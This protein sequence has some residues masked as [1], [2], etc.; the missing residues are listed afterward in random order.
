ML[1]L[2]LT[3]AVMGAQSEFY[4]QEVVVS[5]S[6]L[7]LREHPSVTSGNVVATL[8]RGT[9]LSVLGVHND[10]EVVQVD[11][12]FG[13]WYKVQSAKGQTGY[14]F[15]AFVSST[16]QVLYEDE[17]IPTPQLPPL[18]WYGVYQRD[19][20]SDEVRRID[21]RLVSQYD[22]LSD[23][24][25]KVLKTNQKEHSKFVIGSLNA[26]PLGYVGPLGATDSPGWFFEGGLEPGAM[27]PISVGQAPGDSTVGETYFLAATG[28]AALKNNFVQ[29]SGYQLQV[30]ELRADDE[31]LIQNL[32]P[33]VNPEMG[34]NPTVNLL[35]YGDLDHDHRPD[36]LIQDCPFELGC[37]NSLFLSSKAQ[38]GELLHKV[39]EYFFYED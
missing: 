17:A 9:V 7:K 14:V 4:P 5:A 20:F 35:W 27:Q 39:C 23:T 11:T 1:W 30:L 24:E 2:L 19:S 12:F 25:V 6:A 3:G 21:V 26:L 13:P 15:G 16:L 8:A 28:C 10:G 22:E 31:A 18:Q 29:I 37:R 32:T 33:W 36:A 34:I 38:G